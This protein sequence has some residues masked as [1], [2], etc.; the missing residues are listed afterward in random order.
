MPPPRLAKA[1]VFE[2]ATRSRAKEE[3]EAHHGEL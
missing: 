1:R 2:G 3:K